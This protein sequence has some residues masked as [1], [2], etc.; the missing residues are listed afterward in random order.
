MHDKKKIE[1]EIAEGGTRGIIIHEL[2]WY[3]EVFSTIKGY[4]ESSCIKIQ[5]DMST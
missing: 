4:I 2:M 5:T 1:R 3:S